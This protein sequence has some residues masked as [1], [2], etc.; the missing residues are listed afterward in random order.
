MKK[1]ISLPKYAI[2]PAIITVLTHFTVYYIPM[3]FGRDTVRVLSSRLD[4]SIPLVPGFVFIYVSAFVM[5]VVMYVYIYSMSPYMAKRMLI[6]DLLAKG[7]CAVCYCLY[8]CTLIRPETDEI[9]GFGAWALKIIYSLD[10]PTNLLPSMHCYMSWLC[11]RP[12]LSRRAKPSPLWLKSFCT[13]LAILIFVS[14][15]FTKQHMAIDVVTGV[16][17]AEAGWLIAGGI[18]GKKT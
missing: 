4:E 1:R 18:L 13:V 6:A 9:V 12:L 15:L 5:W 8:P 2:L 10:K 16:L 14:T 17:C 11:A 7:V 3:L